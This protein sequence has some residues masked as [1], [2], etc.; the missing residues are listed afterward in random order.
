MG[1][2]PTSRVWLEPADLSTDA[3]TTPI[4]ARV[5]WPDRPLASESFDEIRRGLAL[6]DA[7]GRS[8][9]ATVG[10]PVGEL[11]LDRGMAEITVTPDARL[12]PGW[13]VVRLDGLSAAW[14]TFSHQRVVPS[15]KGRSIAVR[16]HVG[17]A[18]IIQH[19]LLCPRAG[20]EWTVDAELSERVLEGSAL[21]SAELVRPAGP[22][23]GRRF[24]T[25]PSRPPADD[26][27]SVMALR[28]TCDDI[29]ADEHLEIRLTADV[30]A[31]SGESMRAVTFDASPA[32]ALAMVS[33]ACTMVR[34]VAPVPIAGFEPL[35]G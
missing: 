27:A 35:D 7:A 24:E 15:G 2:L 12:V 26:G 21:G 20:G 10:A 5:Q 14:D 17:N 4:T 28:W 23:C 16:F 11:A 3:G 34:G 22:D 32:R 31:L 25:D 18:P 29:V 1:P 19:V 30:P 13:Y 6:Y 33:G 8:V 9:P